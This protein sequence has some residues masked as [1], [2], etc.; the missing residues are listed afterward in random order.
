MVIIEQ[1]VDSGHLR[2]RGEVDADLP[3]ELLL[4]LVR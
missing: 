2:A 4:G 1:L 3:Q